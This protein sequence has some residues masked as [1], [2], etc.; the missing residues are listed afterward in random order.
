MH[1]YQSGQGQR[2]CY[3]LRNKQRGSALITALIFLVILTILGVSTMTT[4]RLEIK[5]AANTQFAHQA[6]QAAESGIAQALDFI[7]NDDS[8]SLLVTSSTTGVDTDYYFNQSANGAY[9]N[10]A[11]SLKYLEKSRANV[12]YEVSAKVVD[13]FSLGG[14][15]SAYHFRI[16]ATGQSSAGSES[17]NVQGFFKVGPG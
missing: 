15:F 1:H 11:D 10:T 7:E 12:L 9:T 6:F 17:Q 5:M 14:P 8:N 13:G 16:L 2:N 4:S 3:R